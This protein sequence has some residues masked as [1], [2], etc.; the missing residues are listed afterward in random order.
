ML[1]S[2]EDV[3]AYGIHGF[4][5]FNH[6]VDIPPGQDGGYAAAFITNSLM[7]SPD[8]RSVYTDLGWRFGDIY[9]NFVQITG[10]SFLFAYSRELDRNERGHA[11]SDAQ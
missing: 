3:V 8:S 1:K 2:N 5:H 9:P 10:T 6:I 4:M 11:V 7:F